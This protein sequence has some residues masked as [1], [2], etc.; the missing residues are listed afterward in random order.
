[1]NAFDLIGAGIESRKFC[2]FLLQGV[3]GSGKTEVYLN[4]ID[5]ALALWA[6]ARCCWCPRSR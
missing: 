4:A 6:A 3:T 5:A 2:T 1:L